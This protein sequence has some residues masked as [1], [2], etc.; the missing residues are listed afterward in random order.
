VVEIGLTGAVVRILN[1]I[2]S[3]DSKR[4]EDDQKVIDDDSSS[5]SKK[6]GDDKRKVNSKGNVNDKEY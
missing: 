1:R 6:G 2:R 4:G 5:D 3:S